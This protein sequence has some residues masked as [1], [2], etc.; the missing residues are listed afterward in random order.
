MD[1]KISYYEKRLSE[2]NDLYVKSNTKTQKELLKRCISKTIESFNL[3]LNYGQTL[4]KLMALLDEN[5]KE[6]FIDSMAMIN[7]IEVPELDDI[8]PSDLLPPE[9]RADHE[10]Y[11]QLLKDT[12]KLLETTKNE[13]A[14]IMTTHHFSVS[15]FD[16]QMLNR[17][18]K[19]QTEIL[20]L[21][22]YKQDLSRFGEY[23]VYKSILKLLEMYLDDK[24]AAFKYI[25]FI[26]DMHNNMLAKKAMYESL[27]KGELL[28]SYLDDY[29]F[30]ADRFI[31]L[32]TRLQ[33]YA[34]DYYIS[35]GGK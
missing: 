35:S 34:E 31:E 30:E 11:I 19:E 32:S 21:Q 33:E 7:Q 9:D 18:F 4:I 8:P 2:F 22:L 6:S 20:F 5:N 13:G 16:K 10:K 1:N 25:A 3:H 12:N 24:M 28:L 26:R 29:E 14:R 15:S 23:N 27:E 17:F